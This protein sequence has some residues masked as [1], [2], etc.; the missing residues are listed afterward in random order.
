M[1]LG[2][3]P[4]LPLPLAVRGP[5]LGCRWCPRQLS[6]AELHPRRLSGRRLAALGVP[7]TGSSV[8]FGGGGPSLGCG[9]GAPQVSAGWAG[10]IRGGTAALV[11]GVQRV[12]QSSGWLLLA[13][14]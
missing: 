12:Q 9:C 7:S 5:D 4:L 6:A 14:R 10:P 3:L 11:V 2:L 1:A 8:A 13:G